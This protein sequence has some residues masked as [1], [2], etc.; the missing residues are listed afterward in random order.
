MTQRRAELYVVMQLRLLSFG[1][2][3]LRRRVD[4]L[5]AVLRI[6]ALTA[7]LLVIPAAAALSATVRDRA[8]Q[9]AA[10]ARAEVRPV[11]ARTLDGTAQAVPSTLGLTTTPVRIR[12]YDGRGAPHEAKADVLIGTKAGTELTI[13]LDRSGAM[14]PAPRPPADSAAPAVATGITLPMLAWPLIF[15]L[16]RLSRRPLDRRRAEEWAREWRQVSPRW[17]GRQS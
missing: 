3:P 4:R 10:Q 15:G 13:W 5:E 2:N 1:N 11:Q 12:W 14:R 17:T 16:F 7:A 6:V 9:S 8:E